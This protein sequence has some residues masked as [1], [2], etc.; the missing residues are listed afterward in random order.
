MAQNHLYYGDN[1]DIMRRYL[2]D[3]SVDL[4]YLD[5]PFNSDATYNVLFR[6][7]D[8]S[9]AP[10]QIQAFADTWR[11]DRAALQAY[12]ET[13]EQGGDT[14][15]ILQAF[16][17]FL[18]D[19]N[20]LAYLSMMAPRLK[21][22]RR[23]MKHSASVYLHCDPTAGHYL[24]LLM[25]AVFGSKYFK[26]EIIWHYGLGGKAPSDRFANKHDVILFY[27]KSDENAF[28]PLRGDVTEAMRR[29]YSHEDE[30][31]RYMI[32]YGKKYYLKGGK[33]YDDVWEIPT[34]APTARER[35]HYPTQKPEALLRRIIKASSSP[36]GVVLDP[37]CGCGTTVVAAHALERNWT[38]IDITHLAIG[39]MKRR[40]QDVYGQDVAQEYEVIGEP[41]S[42]AGAQQLAKQDPYQFEFWALD[43]VG[44]RPAEEHRGSDRGIDGRLYFH[45]EHGGRTKQVI[46]SVKSGR[47]GPQDVRD[48]RGVIEREDAEIGVLI[49]MREPTR[50]MRSEAASAGYYDAPHSRAKWGRHP[51]IQLLTIQDLLKGKDIDMPP[52]GTSVTFKKAPRDRSDSGSS[53]LEFG[54]S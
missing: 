37:F 49:T 2:N 50:A 43:L 16:R 39:L 21:E 8:G 40:L 13:V 31:G 5:P 22:I 44:A 41:V 53:Q 34:I 47:T 3:E 46:L 25:D 12:Q 54:D 36:G 1:L 4:V 19:S 9:R 18:G 48:L 20:M 42:L 29:K 24:K 27:S 23:V 10:A 30:H 52:A 17:T 26:N 33:R 35:Q 15:R 28:T 45:D 14:S 51:R 11:W 7:R 6:Q 38:G 32:S